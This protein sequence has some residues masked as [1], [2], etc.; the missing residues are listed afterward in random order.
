MASA[1]SSIRSR[2]RRA[3]GSAIG[4]ALLTVAALVP[5]ARAASLNPPP[6]DFEQCRGHGQMTICH[7]T[8]VFA[9]GG[10]PTGVVCGSGTTAFEIVDDPGFVRQEAT[11]WYDA[12]GDLVRRDVHEVWLE[13][14]WANLTAGT[15]VTY[16]QAVN[17]H[18]VFAVPGD[19][20]TATETTTGVVNFL[21]PGHGAIVR[22]AGRTVIGFDGTVESRSG[23]QAFLDFFF[24]GDS[25]AL[26]P[27]CDALAG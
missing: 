3:L 27:L 24:D 6:P 5:A 22:N 12:N 21:V 17:Y 9:V 18:D 25:A 7:G 13:S 23:P 2:F 20:S 8:Q 10:D 4:G 15:S 19:T 14:A 11:R 1:R 26:Q 16:R